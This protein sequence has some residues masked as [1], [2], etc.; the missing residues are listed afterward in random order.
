M[1]DTD[2][3]SLFDVVPLPMLI[4]ENG[5]VLHVNI[6]FISV[7][8]YASEEV[9]GRSW[10]AFLSED[11][12]QLVTDFTDEEL[13]ETIGLTGV[14][15]DGRRISLEW[16]NKGFQ[17]ADRKVNLVTLRDI[18]HQK[19]SD[20][21]LIQSSIELKAYVQELIKARDQ[22]LEAVRLK[23]EFLAVMSHE[24]RTPMNGV[25][26]MASLLLDTPL[27][28]QQ[29]AYAETVRE[30]G[31]ALLTIIDDIL[32]FSK[33]EAGKLT[34]EPIPFDLTKTLY[35]VVE[36]LNH[37]AEDKGLELVLDIRDS[38][39]NHLIGDRG[40]IRQIILNYANNALKFTHEGRVEIKIYPKEPV[41]GKVPIR[42]EISDTGIG[43]PADKLDHVF[44]KFTQSDTST[45]RKY[46]GTGLGLAI[47]SQLA[48]LMG[49]QVGVASTVN[50]GSTFWVEVPLQEDVDF[51]ETEFTI[52]DLKGVRVLIFD[53]NRVNFYLL[54]EHMKNLKVHF[55]LVT[56]IESLLK[57]IKTA[58][59]DGLPFQMLITIFYNPLD[60]SRY[61]MR[62]LTDPAIQKMMLVILNANPDKGDGELAETLGAKVYL[63]VPF[64]PLDFMEAIGA[65]WNAWELDE[66]FEMITRHKLSISSRVKGV[67]GSISI[68][69]Y[70]LTVLLVEDNRV[71]QMVASQMLKKLNCKVEVAANGKIGLEKLMNS[72]Y[73]IVFMDCQ[74]PIMDGYEAT[75]RIRELEQGTDKHQVIVAMTANAM[76]GDRAR[77]LE[78]GMD[79]YISKPIKQEDI[80]KAL[81]THGETQKREEGGRILLVEDSL[82]ARMLFKRML[83]AAGY[84]V[85]EAR[86][87]FEAL[88]L[89][90][91]NELSLIIT[92]LIMPGME[93]LEFIKKVARLFP[94]LKII[95]T[96]GKND[97]SLK[98][99][100]YLGAT[101]VLQKAV[102]KKELIT[103]V[104]EVMDMP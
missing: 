96:S 20:E 25:M 82:S 42:V 104:R 103:T 18:S 34:I 91:D 72:R 11:S 45:T 99:A 53:P 77:C 98:T 101:R 22:A 93:G 89:L 63:P 90:K 13:H 5:I 14:C 36:L 78:A 56:N 65:A 100:G 92:D 61:E 74:M 58:E 54:K 51:K 19:K 49:G 4:Q 48:K 80:I 57:E 79:D 88:K 2:F 52:G 87:G 12:S 97:S 75:R 27:E 10:H 44:E 37:K 46:G 73:A 85:I 81:R 40:R 31:D 60:A 64:K 41:N 26:G 59:D 21:G 71:N 69:D 17:L 35:D 95:A 68:I 83:E 33:I 30:S 16:E 1:S 29:R 3:H 102:L 70:G 6:A 7:F 39:P 86:D 47:V 28:D 84:E 15:K 9:I 32:D 66:P 55:K 67:V 50:K 94:D 8:G 76:A 24:I 23:S 38:T 62:E 43:I